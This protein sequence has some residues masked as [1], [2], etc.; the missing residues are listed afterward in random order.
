MMKA[1]KWLLIFQIY[2]EAALVT[3]PAEMVKFNHQAK[4]LNW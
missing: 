4:N 1:V 3:L 2:L